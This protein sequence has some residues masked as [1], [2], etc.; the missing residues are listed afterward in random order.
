MKALT[1]KIIHKLQFLASECEPNSEYK[2][3]L[4]TAIGNI[5]R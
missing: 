3:R 2:K 1:D 5:E 4:L